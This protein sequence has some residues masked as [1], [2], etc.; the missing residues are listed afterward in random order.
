MQ[1]REIAEQQQVDT[2]LVYEMRTTIDHYF[3]DLPDQLREVDEVRDETKACDYELVAHLIACLALFLFRLD[4]RNHRNQKRK[5]LRFRRNYKKLFGF[6]MPHGD[7]MNAVTGTL[8]EAQVEQLKQQLVRSLLSR[9]VFR[10]Q[11]YQNRWYRIAIDGSGVV[12]F[13]HKHCDQCLHK[14]SKN[15]KVTYSHQVLEARLVTPNGF[16]ISLA[17]EWIENPEGVE[18]DKQDCERNAFRR[19]AKKLKDHF[20]RLSLLIL[21][22]GLYPYEGFFA[23]CRDYGRA[24]CTTFKEGNLPSLWEE[25]HALQPI[26]I[27]HHWCETRYQP[28]AAGQTQVD[29][30]YDRGTD[31]DYQG[32]TLNWIHCEEITT[33]QVRQPDGTLKA[34]TESARFVHIT[35]LSVERKQVADLSQTGRLRWKIENE[36][37]NTLKNGGYGMEHKWARKNYRALKNYYQFMQRAHLIH[38]LM[39]KWQHFV[40]RHLQ[41]PNHPTVKSLWEDM[42]G[43]MQW[44]KVKGKQLRQWLETPVQFRFVT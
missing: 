1:K 37:F 44:S 13:D 26:Q 41:G 7:T 17:S 43:A 5:K 42:P 29:Q 15:G 35:S 21:A 30:H 8:D 28:G 18:Y 14:T 22:D 6:A 11:R 3:P 10:D 32:Y 27:G 19:L 12:T 2:A 31:P 9:K 25:I 23:T 38:P 33:R 20:P 24:W 4:S 40:N 39:L 34:T 36:G 16:S